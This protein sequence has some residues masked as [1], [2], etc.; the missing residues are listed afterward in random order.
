M[1]GCAAGERCRLAQPLKRPPRKKRRKRENAGASAP[2]VR[3]AWN[4][5]R[6]QRR[7]GRLKQSRAPERAACACVRTAL[8]RCR[9]ARR[10]QRFASAARATA[11][12]LDRRS[13][14]LAVSH[15][16]GATHS[17]R[18]GARAGRGGSLSRVAAAFASRVRHHLCSG[19]GGARW[20]SPAS[21]CLEPRAA[22]HSGAPS[23]P[24]AAHRSA[25][26]QLKAV[27]LPI[28]PSCAAL[29]IEL[30]ACHQ[31]RERGPQPVAHERLA[32][33]VKKLAIQLAQVRVDRETV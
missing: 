8:R 30:C 13:A 12:H 19:L 4:S 3:G 14:L 15:A 5:A 11:S 29:C 28:H 1:P 32:Q 31:R 21:L 23:P 26:Q 25:L 24:A 10:G 2:S 6:A 22:R 7:T 9:S 27:S 18:G 16:A 20:A 17:A 33:A